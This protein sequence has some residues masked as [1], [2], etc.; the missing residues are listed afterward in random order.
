MSNE[1]TRLTVGIPREADPSERRVAVVPAVVPALQKLGVDV[2][3]QAGAGTESGFTDGDYR[4]LQA[5]VIE[6]RDEVFRQADVILQV[7]YL[8]ACGE[9]GV[10]DRVQAIG[11]PCRP[12]PGQG[13]HLAHG[14]P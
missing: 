3:V 2:V 6:S 4:D 10:D 11:E 7:R 13:E 12:S 5:A 9:A 1:L 14:H 8:G